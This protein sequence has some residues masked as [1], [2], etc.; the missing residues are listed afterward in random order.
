MT[1]VLIKQIICL[2]VKKSEKVEYSHLHKNTYKY[3]STLFSCQQK[4][5]L[6]IW[7]HNNLT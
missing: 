7:K 4:P 3:C 2:V 1:F 6:E 5:K